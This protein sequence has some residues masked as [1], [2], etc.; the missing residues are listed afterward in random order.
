[1]DGV[2]GWDR[3]ELIFSSFLSFFLLPFLYYVVVA[4]GFVIG[5]AYGSRRRR[6]LLV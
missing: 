4:G 5:L 2:G 3:Q 1:M 6:L